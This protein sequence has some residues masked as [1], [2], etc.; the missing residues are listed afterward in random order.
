MPYRGLQNSHHLLGNPREE[1]RSDVFFLNNFSNG[2]HVGT[3]CITSYLKVYHKEV[4]ETYNEKRTM[5]KEKTTLTKREEEESCEMN[6]GDVRCFDVRTNGGRQ[7]F[8]Q[9]ASANN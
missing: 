7:S 3:G 8:L 6:N 4:W 5:E 1:D 9:K 2:N